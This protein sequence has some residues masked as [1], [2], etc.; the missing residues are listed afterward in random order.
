MAAIT[1]STSSSYDYDQLEQKYQ[2]FAAPSFEILVGGVKLADQ[3]CQLQSIEINIPVGAGDGVRRSEASSCTFQL[4]G[5]FDLDKSAFTGDLLAK[6][7]VGKK[8]EVNGGYNTRITL[9]VGLIVHVRH[10]YSPEGISITV[11][12]M[13]ASVLL[14]NIKKSVAYEQEDQDAVI[15]KLLEQ[16]T[17]N[18]YAKMGK[19]SKIGQN[20]IRLIQSGMDDSEFI[21]HLARR[22]GY[23]FAIIHG[24]VIF[25]ELYKKTGAL[26]TLE[27]GRHL[28]SF[29]KELDSSRQIG[30]VT[31]SSVGVGLAPELAQ[32]TATDISG[33]GSKTALA[34]MPALKTRQ[35]DYQDPLEFTAA[36]LKRVAQA[37]FN[38]R[39]MEFVSGRGS[40]IGLPELVPGRYLKIDGMDKHTNGLYFIS[41]VVH[42]YSEQGFT[43]DFELKG[44]RTN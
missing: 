36:G 41:R 29:E 23:C 33:T 14:R 26:M 5:Q 39:S 21:T 15:Q 25:T 44:A 38:E 7:E 28:K 10:T 1:F 9:F 12:A 11:E 32:I 18:G 4:S 6:L 31:V 2:G 35:L 30:K 27:Y 43:T 37:I 17:V 24:Q 20:K 34:M 19:V 42:R 40:C 22:A 3:T 13:D 16:C 8:V